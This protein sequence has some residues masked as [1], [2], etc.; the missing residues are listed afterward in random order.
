MNRSQDR[1]LKALELAIAGNIIDFGVKNNV[2]IEEEPK[3]ILTEKNKVIHK[4]SV[5]H[6]SEFKRALK[7]AKNI[8]YLA[9]NV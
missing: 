3:R 7:R 4:K 6:Y 5:F 1:L 8:L 9:D 2:N